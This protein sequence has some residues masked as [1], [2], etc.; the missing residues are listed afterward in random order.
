MPTNSREYMNKYYHSNKKKFY[1]KYDRTFCEC[2][3]C[4]I[5]SN[6]FKRHLRSKKHQKYFEMV[7]SNKENIKQVSL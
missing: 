1:N 2:C 6:K 5:Q 7:Q 4:T 3:N